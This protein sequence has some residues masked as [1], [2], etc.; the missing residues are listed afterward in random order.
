MKD[1]FSRA[2]AILDDPADQAPS[3]RQQ[4]AP[5]DLIDAE[6]IIV[7][8]IYCHTLKTHMWL[9]RDEEALANHPDI[10]RSGLPVFFFDEVE[11]LRGKTVKYLQTVAMVKQ[12]CPTSRVMQ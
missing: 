9:V 5:T 12:Q 1:A 6:Q 7:V 10:I 8:L 4:R 11:Q 2:L 3:T